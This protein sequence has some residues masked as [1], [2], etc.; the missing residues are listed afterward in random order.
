MGHHTLTPGEGDEN[1]DEKERI[2]STSNVKLHT[3]CQMTTRHSNHVG[4][5]TQRSSFQWPAIYSKHSVT[6]L[7]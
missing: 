5:I 4:D 7:E 6:F 2:K 3:K 1:D